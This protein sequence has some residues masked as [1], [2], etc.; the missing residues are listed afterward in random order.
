M[1]IAQRVQELSQGKTSLM[2]PGV[3]GKR[4]TKA[5]SGRQGRKQ[6]QSRVTL[7]KV[8]GF[9]SELKALQ[10]PADHEMCIVVPSNT[11]MV[12]G[13]PNKSPAP[14]FRISR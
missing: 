6:Y 13:R 12:D 7:A 5:R 3:L 14:H 2:T 9:A 11:G 1:N 4:T 8:G 10:A